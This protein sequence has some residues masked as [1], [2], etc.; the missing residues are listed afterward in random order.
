MILVEIQE[1]KITYPTL[2]E[3]SLEMKTLIQAI[4]RVN[5]AR[6]PSA[7]FPSSKSFCFLICF[8]HLFRDILTSPLFKIIL[9]KAKDP[10]QTKLH[11]KVL[12]TLKRGEES[13]EWSDPDRVSRKS[14]RRSNS[15]NSPALLLPP[16]S[17]PRISPHSPLN[18]PSS[19]AIPPRPSFLPQTTKSAKLAT[20]RLTWQYG[21]R[22][23][24]FLMKVPPLLSFLLDS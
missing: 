8:S 24:V 11:Q 17:G 9:N 3:R 18:S 6:R 14:R 13:K 15:Q 21:I 16:P 20:S 12:L 10:H 23:F 1:G 5:P 19:R 2:P 7:R 22:S 4:L